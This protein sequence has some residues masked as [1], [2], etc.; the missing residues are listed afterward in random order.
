MSA[1]LERVSSSV[2]CLELPSEQGI[3]FSHLQKPSSIHLT[4][5]FIYLFNIPLKTQI[6]VLKTL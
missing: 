1:A 6:P 5:L 4:N 2:G 3:F